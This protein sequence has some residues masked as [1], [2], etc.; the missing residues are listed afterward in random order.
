[1]MTRDWYT[2]IATLGPIGYLVLPGTMASV[3]TLP[4][5]CFIKEY[6]PYEFFY[7]LIT[8]IIG[9]ASFF[10]I[11]HALTQ[12][13]RFDDPPEVVIDELV[14]CMITF[15]G[16]TPSTP[17]LFVGLLLFRF[18]DIIKIGGIQHLEKCAGAWGILL[19]DVAAGVISNIIL[20]LLF[21]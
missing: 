20:R 10:V 1:M 17:T 8:A 12:L 7:Y 14:G 2:R 5:I 21:G 13:R 3:A 9:F 19:D 11:T 15:L 18:F 6:L 16:I 4:I